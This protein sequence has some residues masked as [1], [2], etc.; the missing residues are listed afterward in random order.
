AVLIKLNRLLKPGGKHIFGV[1]V[2]GKAFLDSFG[3]LNPDE[4]RK[5]FGQQDHIRRFSSS[6]LKMSL[7][8]VVPVNLDIH[9]EDEFSE[10]E[11]MQYNIPKSKW[12]NYVGYSLF[13]LDKSDLLL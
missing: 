3:S 2:M 13:F 12:R 6:D 11:L 10:Q 1:P 7:G 5:Y 9:L 4:N 8:M